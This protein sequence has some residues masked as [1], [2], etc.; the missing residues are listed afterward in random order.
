MSHSVANAGLQARYGNILHCTTKNDVLKQLAPERAEHLFERKAKTIRSVPDFA[1]LYDMGKEVMPSTH[2]YMKVNFA[3]RKADNLECVVK[4]RVKPSC[5]R[6]RDD[7]RAWRQNTE[8]LLNMPECGGIAVLR[9]VIEDSKAFYVVME[10][11]GGHDL[12]ESL[13]QEGRWPLDSVKDVIQQLLA[14]LAHLHSQGAIHKDLKLENVML[15]SSDS[16]AGSGVIVNPKSV[17]VIDF[18]TVVVW[19][20]S[21]P[22][23]KDVVGTDQYIS[24]EGYAG[25][26]TP[27]SDMFAVGVIA[28]KLLTSRFPFH[29]SL[30]DDE[31]G[32]NWVGSPKMAQIRRKLKSSKVDF[33]HRAF[34]ENQHALQL[35]S[36]LL[37]SDETSR[38]TAAAALEHPWFQEGSLAARKGEENRKLP[39]CTELIDDGVIVPDDD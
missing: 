16:R 13:E 15:D 7:E 22:T 9:D 30:F 24:Q 19:S 32:E 31:P 11:V 17:K 25:K 37:S 39:E 3:T 12:F 10:K 34:S 33:S 1:D 29:D 21:T 8:F 2:S 5:F 28:Y 4:I 14:S 23:A 38:P 6:S 36:S 35:V 26:Y 18:D 27:L 20:P